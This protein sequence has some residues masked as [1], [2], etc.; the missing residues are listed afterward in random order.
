M[1]TSSRRS[2]KITKNQQS[3][4]SCITQAL[5]DVRPCKLLKHMCSYLWVGRYISS[6]LYLSQHYRIHMDICNSKNCLGIKTMIQYINFSCTVVSR[7]T[8]S[9]LYQTSGYTE[10][11]YLLTERSFLPDD[12][13][14]FI[15]NLWIYRTIFQGTD[16]FG[17]ARDNCIMACSNFQGFLT[18]VTARR[19]A[20]PP[21]SLFR[22][23]RCASSK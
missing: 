14:T 1:S 22:C 4:Q 16:R 6:C 21:T 13:T 3:S 11:F 7:Y 12:G 5:R 23:C 10:R 8:E 17:R 18:N 9:L 20:L 2:L 19:K 15:P